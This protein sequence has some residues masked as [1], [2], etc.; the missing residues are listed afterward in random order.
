MT[1][2]EQ[3][4]INMVVKE[5]RLYCDCGEGTVWWEEACHHDVE[6]LEKMAAALIETRAEN[7]RLRKAWQNADTTAAALSMN[8]G[9]IDVDGL[10]VGPHMVR[11]WLSQ[12][13]ER[14]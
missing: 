14:T 9:Y 5:F 8:A 3:S 4:A 11:S 12:L 7:E 13:S 6:A 10:R 2:A 1:D